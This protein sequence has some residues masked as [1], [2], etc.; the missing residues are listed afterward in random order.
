MAKLAFLFSGQGSQKIGMGKAFWDSSSVAQEIYK[1]ADDVLGYEISRISFEGPDDELKLTQN[2]QPALL[3]MSYIA[4]SVLGM[5]PSI[6]AGHS[7]GRSRIA[8]FSRRP[9]ASP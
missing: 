5:R 6:A 7:L 4:Y 9:F 1:Q 8:F 2:T 3:I